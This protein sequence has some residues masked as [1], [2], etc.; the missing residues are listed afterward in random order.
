MTR[1]RWGPPAGRGRRGCYYCR[2]DMRPADFP[3]SPAS[4][5][6]AGEGLAQTRLR[7]RSWTLSRLGGSSGT[8]LARSLPFLASVSRRSSRSL[9]RALDHATALAQFTLDAHARFADL[10]LEAVAGGRRRGARSG[11]AAPAS[12][13]SMSTSRRVSLTLV[14]DAVT[15]DQGGADGDQHGALGVVAER[16][17]RSRAWRSASGGSSTRPGAW[18]ACGR[19]WRASLSPWSCRSCHACVRSCFSPTSLCSRLSRAVSSLSRLL[20]LW[21]KLCWQ[22]AF[23]RGLLSRLAGCEERVFGFCSC[24]DADHQL[25][26]HLFVTRLR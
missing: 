20:L 3:A 19:P 4:P 13:C 9:T 10:A 6:R 24:S 17:R 15:G 2:R 14:D 21:G 22:W 16:R 5:V 1:G 26:E 23:W 25:P 12:W 8:R 18:R 11:A 7:M